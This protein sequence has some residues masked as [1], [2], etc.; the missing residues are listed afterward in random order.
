MATGAAQWNFLL[1]NGRNEPVAELVRASG[2]QVKFSRNMYAEAQLVLSHQ[3]PEAEKLLNLLEEGPVPTLRAYR[4]SP[5]QTSGVLRFNGYL[6][7]FTETA[8]RDSPHHG[9]VPLALRSVVWRRHE[10]HGP[11]HAGD[12]RL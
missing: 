5:G 7:P 12:A 10:R 11:I 2:R 1:C 6:A 3:D 4:K 9:H 8:R